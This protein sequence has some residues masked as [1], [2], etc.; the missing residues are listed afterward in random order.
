MNS[1]QCDEATKVYDK[2]LLRDP[3]D[4]KAWIGKGDALEKLGRFDEA[5]KAYDKA[6]SP[7]GW[8]K[9]ATIF[10]KIKQ[11]HRGS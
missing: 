4:S 2:V 10:E 11:M 8:T 7:D 5:Y 6:A 3:I 9:K 1:G